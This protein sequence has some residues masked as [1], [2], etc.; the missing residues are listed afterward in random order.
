MLKKHQ[1]ISKATLLTIALSLL[2]LGLLTISP[3]AQAVP[4]FSR[5]TGAACSMCHV[6]AFG[7]DLT[8]YGRDFK[9][10]GYTSGENSKLPPVSAMVMGSFTNTKKNQDPADLPPG[11]GFN[12]NNNFTFDQASLFY[13]GR[14]WDQV[15]AF[16][17][18]T[19]DGVE[20]RLALD[21]TDVRFSDQATLAGQDLVY[22]ISAN[23]LP[24]VQD[25]WNTT[26]VWGFPF[27]SSPIAP[28][29]SAAALI[30]GGLGA[31][32]V[33]GATLYSMINRLLYVEAGAY[34][35]FAKNFQ[36]A[37][38][39]WAPDQNVIDGGAPYWRVALQ[40]NWDG[41][42]VEIGHYGFR[43]NVFPGGDRSF[44]TDRYTDLAVDATYQY[45][46]DMTHI[47][48]LRS[49]YIR[50]NQEL[51]ATHAA[52]GSPFSNNQLNTFKIN[53]AYTF[54]QT[55]G[56]TF[57]YNRITGTKNTGIYNTDAGFAMSGKPD[58]EFFT[59]DLSYVPFGKNY[60]ML[61]S[62]MNLHVGLTYIGYNKF[63]GT[64]FHAGD[65]NTLLLNGWLAF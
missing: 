52:G 39:A 23:N 35:T 47:F 50:E 58:S 19:F 26:P 20:N 30:D 45:L 36:Q 9:L 53:A 62:L 56:L 34:T 7:P 1:P 54:Q 14:I 46:G 24:T 12:A 38:G 40:H 13:A 42:Y 18:L 64:S 2:G 16:S 27:N 60:S 3:G 22:G 59:V 6:S 63:N 49:T 48:E 15:G 61:D 51:F 37:M 28:A 41:Q 10:N 33:G 57:A 17:Q 11:N 21:N 4:S 29:P 32:Q 5:Q 43:A 55:Y 8:P 31:T 65:N 25:L 44:G